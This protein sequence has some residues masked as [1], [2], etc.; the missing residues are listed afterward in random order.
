MR[1][2]RDLRISRTTDRRLHDIIII[3]LMRNRVV[4]MAPARIL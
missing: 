2:P 4:V 1:L 3:V